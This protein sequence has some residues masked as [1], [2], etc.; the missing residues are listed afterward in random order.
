MPR[1]NMQPNT[2]KSW[3]YKGKIYVKNIRKI[4]V[5]SETGSGST[6]MSDPYWSLIILK[7]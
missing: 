6:T 5:G 4:L 2:L 1:H 7:Y 3:K